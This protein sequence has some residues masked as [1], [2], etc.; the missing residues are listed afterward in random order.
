[1]STEAAL[2]RQTRCVSEHEFIRMRRDP[3]PIALT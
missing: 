1:M 3:A 2:A